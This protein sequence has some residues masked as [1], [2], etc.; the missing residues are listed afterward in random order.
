MN[1]LEFKDLMGDYTVFSLNNIRNLV[2]SF[3]PRRL[4]EWKNKGY[5]RNII[6][7]FYIF[8]DIEL[9]ENTLFEISNRIY[10]PSC[11]SLETALSYY[12]LIPEAVFSITAVS[13]R[14][15]CS[16]RTKITP[17]SYRTVKPE[18]FFGFDI[19]RYSETKSFRIARIEKAI[20]DCLYI[21]TALKT[22]DDFASLRILA[23]E[24]LTK[25]DKERFFE[26]TEKFKNKSLAKRAES[27]WRH[28]TNA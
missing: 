2:P 4:H 25:T 6:K 11:I 10:S 8:S 13:T 23:D 1:Y 16:F 12:G 5:L 7:G 27:F 28:V 20:L 18:L 9:N 24:L 19:I 22:A 26:Y 15:T 17:F 3:D 14:K 21:N